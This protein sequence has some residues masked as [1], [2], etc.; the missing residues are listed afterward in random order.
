L[1]PAF[2]VE[3]DPR[4]PTLSALTAIKTQL[5]GIEKAQ[6]ETLAQKDKILEAIDQLRIWVRHSGGKAQKVL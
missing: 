4:A 6:Q 3:T 5:V 2:A 1:A